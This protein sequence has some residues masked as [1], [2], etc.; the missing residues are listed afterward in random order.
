MHNVLILPLILCFFIS[1]SSYSI[2]KKYNYQDDFDAYF[3]FTFNHSIS[4][5]EEDILV[6]IPIASC[7]MCVERTLDELIKNN[8]DARI[9]VVGTSHEERYL[10]KLDEIEKNYP[11]LYDSEAEL[12]NYETDM[13]KPTLLILSKNY[14][15]ITLEETAWKKVYELL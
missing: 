2:G 11:L 12:F 14:Q 3:Q 13:G 6:I 9:I 4:K 5:I 1:C 7:S 8:Y 15:Y 10:K